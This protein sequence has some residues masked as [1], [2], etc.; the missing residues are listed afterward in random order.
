MHLRHDYNGDYID[1]ENI[2]AWLKEN[3]KQNEFYTRKFREITGGEY[4][5]TIES[6]AMEIRFH[7]EEDKNYFL[8]HHGEEFVLV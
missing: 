4:S 3:F 1:A 6:D 8:L 2:K 5:V 7:R